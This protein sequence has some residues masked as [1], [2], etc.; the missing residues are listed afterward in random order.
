MAA[1]VFAVFLFPV[2]ISS[3]SDNVQQYKEA[4]ADYV[5]YSRHLEQENKRLVEMMNDIGNEIKTIET[6]DQLDSLRVKY[7][8]T[9]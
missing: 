7:G 8:L 3:Q 1:I 4:L 6:I 2:V 9:E 5:I